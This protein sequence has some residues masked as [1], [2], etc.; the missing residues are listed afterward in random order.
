M[1]SVMRQEWIVT[2]TISSIRMLLAIFTET[3]QTVWEEREEEQ[4]LTP[5]VIATLIS[6]AAAKET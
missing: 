3:Q 2:I 1:I 4:F 6:K 5:L